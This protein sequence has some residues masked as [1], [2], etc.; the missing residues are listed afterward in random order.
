MMKKIFIVGLIVCSFFVVSAS[1]VLAAPITY[2]IFDTTDTYDVTDSSG[3]IVSGKNYLDIKE[4]SCT[5]A[6]KSVELKL[7]LATGGTIQNSDFIF[8]SMSLVTSENKYDI[9]YNNN[10]CSV[11]DFDQNEIGNVNYSGGGTDTLT[12]SFD[13]SNSS[14]E[15]VFVYAITYEITEDEEYFDY[16]PSENIPLFD[17]VGIPETGVT[18]ES[19]SFSANASYGTTPYTFLWKYGDGKTS[20]GQTPTHTYDQAGTYEVIVLV[21]DTNDYSDVYYGTIEITAGDGGDHNG[22][23]NDGGNEGSS[24][25]SGL[26]LF[27][28][29][30]AVIVIAGVAVVVYII[31]R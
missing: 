7:T 3:N 1:T 30:I 19:I 2:T 12:I 15:Y 20:N 24:S 14:E 22:G 16:A 21:T 10:S 6:G 18:G 28:V 27:V 5:P 13:L 31:R 25:N 4:A 11:T 23:A 26:I 17:D 8:Y 29:I 9:F